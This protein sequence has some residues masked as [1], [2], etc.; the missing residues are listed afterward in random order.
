MLLKSLSARVELKEPFF[1]F[2]KEW[3]QEAHFNYCQRPLQADSTPHCKTVE[4]NTHP[5]S[6]DMPK[7]SNCMA[8][9]NTEL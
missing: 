8:K 6:F 9:T 5:Y 3:K 7:T 1:F 2:F 4:W